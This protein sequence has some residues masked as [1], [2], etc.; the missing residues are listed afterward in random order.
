ML[1]LAG[2]SCKAL[3]P[4][5][6]TPTAVIETPA[7][8]AAATVTPLPARP[9][10]DGWIAFV[11]QNNLWIVHP[12]G[13]S[14]QQITSNPYPAMNNWGN[15]NELRAAW[16]PDGSRL[17]F[18]QGASLYLVDL[19]TLKLTL[20]VE[21]S[22]GWF[23]WSP[24]SSRIMYGTRPLASDRFSDD[25]LWVVD[26][27]GGATQRITPNADGFWRPKWSPDG[28]HVLFAN[29]GNDPNGYTIM[30]MSA[31]QPVRLPTNV[32]G[33]T[34][35]GA[36]EW[37]S[38]LIIACITSGSEFP[39]DPVL[40]LIDKDG[41]LVSQ[42]SL[43]EDVNLHESD[44]RWSPDGTRIALPYIVRAFD[45][46]A[47]EAR[48][49]IFTPDTG[50]FSALG[51]GYASDWS[52]DGN[53]IVAYDMDWDGAQTPRLMTLVNAR[54]GE[55][56]PIVEG[57][58]PVWQ[59]PSVVAPP[60]PTQA[61]PEAL[62]TGTPGAAGTLCTS[63]DL[64]LRDTPKGNYLQ[65]CAHGEQFEIGPLEGGG[66][67]M[68]P[69]GKFF[70]YCSNSGRCYAARVGDTRLTLI[71]SVRNFAI[72]RR[73]IDPQFRFEFHGE[74]PYKLQVFE[75]ILVENVL[76]TIPSRITADE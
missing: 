6:P 7:T 56:H 19:A 33:G 11:N 73:G 16:S 48:L 29:P 20:L 5:P 70:V 38:R 4:P 35:D 66:Y 45:I 72:I 60:L 57:F 39:F 13:A 64:T 34:G 46:V 14:L 43:P 1:S 54:T 69:N 17:A 51:I 27:P 42:V 53:W 76:F 25:G 12:D 47:A 8:S 22:N 10:A 15:N 28:S 62:G 41:S 49:D 37:S 9:P 65:M 50:A 74:N 44:L 31:Q 36:C 18:T 26:V 75:D 21:D 3:I 24:D 68:G 67:A 58:F 52:P 59:P 71:G 63:T 61:P 40:Q 30:N 2:L 55:A 32:M 23:G